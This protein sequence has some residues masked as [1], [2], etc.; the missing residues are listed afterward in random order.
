MKYRSKI[1]VSLAFALVAQSLAADSNPLVSSTEE[2]HD[3]QY[4][5]TA[6]EVNEV[7]II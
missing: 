7:T 3:S 2:M 4:Q 6:L 1:V 5:H